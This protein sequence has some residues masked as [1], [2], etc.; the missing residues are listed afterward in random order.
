MIQCRSAALLLLGLATYAL[1]KVEV[2]EP[3]R[4]YPRSAQFSIKAGGKNV[5]IVS[6][7][8]YDYAHFSAD[9]NEDMEVEVLGKTPIKK[10]GIVY[11]RFDEYSKPKL[12]NRKLTWKLTDHKYYILNVK[13]FKELVIAVDPVETNVPSAKAK[14]VFNVA[15]KKYGADKHGHE[16]STKAF[17]NAIADAQKSKEDSPVVFVPRGV[18]LLGNLVLPSKTQLYLAPGAVLQ[19]HGRPK[20]FSVDWTADGEKRSGT[21]FISTAHNSTDIRI[22]G[23]G[24]IDG[25]AYTYKDKNFAPSLVVPVLTKNFTLDGPLLR[26]SGSTA[27][28]VVRS[29]DVTIRNV[30]VLNRINDMKDNGAVDL[31]ESQNVTVQDA[32]AISLA[33]TFTTKA[34]KPPGPTVPKWPGQKQNSSDILF[35]NCLAW[36]GN[37]GFKVGQGAMSD[38]KNIKFFSSTIYD[39]AVAMGIHKKW[40]P[41]TVS[42]VTFDQIIVKRMSYTTSH[43]SG[44]VGSWLALFVEDGKAGVGPINNVPVKNILVLHN[45]GS[46][47]LVQGVPG[48]EVSNVTFDNIFLMKGSGSATKLKDLGLGDMKYAE[49]VTIV[50]D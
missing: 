13:G 1:G 18:Y 24:T 41:G 27:L 11:S 25:N 37:Y 9:N 48:G 28:N 42:N 46:D 38:Q 5:P 39:S 22:F 16:A 23:R 47:P 8:D 12:D 6:Y 36:T 17:K 30:K 14:N 40:G 50:K 21:N 19:M 2:Y 26:E 43:L 32:M 4:L 7:A 49:N 34:S 15:D 10:F 29:K 45:G 33:D 20:E 44:M 31:L 35:S 3:A